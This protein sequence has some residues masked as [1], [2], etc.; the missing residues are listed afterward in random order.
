[1][2]RCINCA[3]EIN[4]GAKVCPYCHL[5]PYDASATEPYKGI[6]GSSGPGPPHVDPLTVGV[7]GALML[8]VFPVV[9]GV[10][11]GGSILYGIWKRGRE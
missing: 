10:L 7:L 3:S 9:G 11:L 2:P 5:H 8:P 1:V 4:V 6:L